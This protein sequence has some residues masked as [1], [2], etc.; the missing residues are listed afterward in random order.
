MRRHRRLVL[1]L[2]GLPLYA[3][4][5][6]FLSTVAVTLLIDPKELGGLIVD[7]PAAPFE[8]LWWLYCGG[9]ALL[10]VASQALFVVPIVR[11]RIETQ[12]S[13]RSLLFSLIVGAM[14]AGALTLGLVCGL[15]ELLDVWEEAINESEAY[16]GWT[17]TLP[18]FAT[19]WLFWSAVLLVFTRRRPGRGL[20]ERLVALLL[21]GTLIEALAMIPIDVMVRRRTNCYCAT[22]TFH[23]L[24]IAAF[25]TMWLTGPGIAILYMRHRRRQAVHRC[26]RCGYAKGPS[27]GPACPECHFAWLD[28]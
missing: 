16:W 19:G 25:A 4:A 21:A 14:V 27:P 3:A 17:M 22:G 24:L 15:L 23:G 28:E 10:V 2:V 18:I 7:F 5:L 8:P 6:M 26:D 20:P 1:I 13:G 11:L 9:P 12:P